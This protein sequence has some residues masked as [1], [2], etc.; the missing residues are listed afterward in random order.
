[1]LREE[2]RPRER[3]VVVTVCPAPWATLDCPEGRCWN[4]LA[5]LCLQGTDSSCSQLPLGLRWSILLCLTLGPITL[6]LEQGLAQATFLR[7]LPIRLDHTVPAGGV[8]THTSLETGSLVGAACPLSFTPCY[9]PRGPALSNWE[10]QRPQCCAQTLRY[11]SCP[12][13]RPGNP[14]EDEQSS[15][16][17]AR[18]CGQDARSPAFWKSTSSSMHTGDLPACHLW[19]GLHDPEHR[20]IS[21]GVSRHISAAPHCPLSLMGGGQSPRRGR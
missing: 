9:G 3:L 17:C 16:Y 14:R 7:A 12:G 8:Q 18:H 10:S 15:T 21:T 11:S 1:M 13:A 5:L 2:R 6:V 19:P 20:H 4:P